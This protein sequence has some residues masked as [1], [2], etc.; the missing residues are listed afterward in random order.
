MATQVERGVSLETALRNSRVPPMYADLLRI[1]QGGALSETALRDTL[2]Q[3]SQQREA[4]SR[5]RETF[6]YLAIMLVASVELVLGVIILCAARVKEIMG[7]WGVELPGTTV[8]LL[9]LGDILPVAWPLLQVVVVLGFGL[10]LW[11]SVNETA[12]RRLSN[13]FALIPPFHLLVLR[14]GELRFLQALAVR[15][16]SAQPLPHAIVE[17]GVASGLDVV[18]RRA[19]LTASRIEKGAAPEDAFDAP[20]VWP[21]MFA[22]PFLWG[23]SPGEIAGGLR[24]VGALHRQRMLQAPMTIVAFIEPL[25]MLAIGFVV[26]IVMIAMFYPLTRLLNDLS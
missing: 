25:L 1:A 16:E 20:G 2:T 5:L 18:A 13:L 26:M 17:A 7:G 8:L 22:I 15:I 14:S 19:T 10:L 23:K 3:W 4:S 12:R 21:A 6:W 24:M 11:G 9:Y